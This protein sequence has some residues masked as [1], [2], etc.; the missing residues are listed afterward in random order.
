M[1]IPII[2]IAAAV[3]N[4]IFVKELFSVIYIMIVELNQCFLVLHVD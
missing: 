2:F 3:G 4:S 1:I